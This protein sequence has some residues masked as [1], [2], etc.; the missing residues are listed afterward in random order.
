MD[1]NQLRFWDENLSRFVTPKGN[2]TIMV[3]ASSDDIRLKGEFF[4]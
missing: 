4:Q 2:Y 3:G 1:K